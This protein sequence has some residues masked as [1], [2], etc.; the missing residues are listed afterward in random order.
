MQPQDFCYWLQGFVELTEG[1]TNLSETQ[2]EC[3]KQHL[4]LVF[5]KE[6]MTFEEIRQHF[7]EPHKHE[8]PQTPPEPHFPNFIC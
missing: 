2:W 3:I 8:K 4:Q 7:G 6:T 5:K 1:Q